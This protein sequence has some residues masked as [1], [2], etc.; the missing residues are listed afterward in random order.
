MADYMKIVA[1]SLPGAKEELSVE[2][3]NLLVS[4]RGGEVGDRTSTHTHRTE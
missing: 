1:Q 4:Q 3:R 2:E